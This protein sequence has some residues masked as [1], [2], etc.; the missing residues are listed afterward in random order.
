MIFLAI[1]GLKSTL[2]L[3]STIVFFLIK[4]FFHKNLDF[5]IFIF[6]FFIFLLLS[7]PTC[8]LRRLNTAV[9]FSSSCY[10]ALWC[11]GDLNNKT[12]S[13]KISSQIMVVSML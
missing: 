4:W 6:Y 3:F 12:Y 10:G 11:V 9:W 2:H 13:I 8:G 1:L 7:C 5:F